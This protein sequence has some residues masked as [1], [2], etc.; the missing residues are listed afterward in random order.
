MSSEAF[1]YLYRLSKETRNPDWAYRHMQQVLCNSIKL[2]RNTATLNLLKKMLKLGL[3]TKEVTKAAE[4][5]N[6]QIV[7]AKNTSKM[8]EDGMKLK[9][10]DAELIAR[11]ARNRLFYSK[12]ECSRVVRRTTFIGVEFERVVAKECKD[13]WDEKVRTHRAKIEFMCKKRSAYENEN[14][15]VIENVKYR[16]VDL[17]E[18]LLDKNDEPIVYGGVT[19]SKNVKEALKLSPNMMAYTPVT[20][21]YIEIEVEKGEFKGRYELMNREQKQND[22]V[23]EDDPKVGDTLNLEE[24]KMNFSGLKAT[25]MKTCARLYYPKPAKFED[26]I[27][28]MNRKEELILV[29][30]KY[31]EEEC[32]SK[33][34]PKQSN[35]TKE[36]INGIKEIKEDKNSVVSKTDKTGKLCI[37]SIKNHAEA[38]APHHANDKKI[39]KQT[40]KKIEDEMNDHLKQHN[41]MWSVGIENEGQVKRIGIASTSTNVPAPT[42]GGLR[43][44]HKPVPAGQEAAGPPLRPVCDARE[45]PNSRISNFLS[46]VINNYSDA[47]ENSCEVKS[48]E[49]MRA[50]FDKFNE[51]IDQETRKRCM[52]L[53]MDIS[54]LFP[55]MKKSTCATAVKDLVIN[56]NLEIENINL[57]EMT[58]YLRVFMS[59]EEIIKDDLEHVL[60]KRAKKSR[61][62][63]TINCLKSDKDDH[64]KWIPAVNSPNEQQKKKIIANVL[65]IGVELVMSKHCYQVGNDTYLQEDRGSIGLELTGALHR[66][67]MMYYDKLYK[68]EVQKAG[69]TLHLIDRYVDDTNVIAEKKNNNEEETTKEMFDIA[70]TIIE[71][72]AVTMDLPSNH[73]DQ[74]LPILDMAC[75]LDSQGNLNYKHF[76]KKTASKLVIPNRSAHSASS[77]RAVHINEL[78]RR[79]MNTSKRLDWN[80]FVAPVLTEYMRRMAKAGYP[81]NYRRNIL[82]NAIFI[83]KGKVKNDENGTSPLNR[84]K[85]FMKSERRKSKLQKRKSWGTNGD[86]LSPIIVPSTPGGKLAKM[87]REVADKAPKNLRFKIVERGGVAIAMC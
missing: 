47:V 29:A 1:A 64:I 33:G 83:Y 55:S 32:D 2:S 35:L 53:S 40:V 73:E 71:D 7:M 43:K 61:V 68:Q 41:K 18:N 62:K 82:K 21:I 12:I 56:S 59:P 86:Y 38:L 84:H 30:K 50:A 70:Q 37:D 23:D 80:E 36:E 58:K 60:P 66:P 27:E 15:P 10:K 74:C 6:K 17:R 19:V 3:G 11:Q 45:A 51:T 42:L 39:D 25:D 75:W 14:E 67:F 79:M 54:S 31:I 49:E 44:D 28:L 69:I 46:R 72:I 85:N 8:I 48:S 81:E 4:I 34:M 63:L 78:V 24:N 9:I 20:A 65:C 77:K 22:D 16:D 13:V 87:M 5:I 52:L 26:E 76:E 57:Y